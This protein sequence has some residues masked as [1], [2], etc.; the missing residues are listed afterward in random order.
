MARGENVTAVAED[1]C[2]MHGVPVGE[3]SDEVVAAA[4][5]TFH[6]RRSRPVVLTVPIDAPDG[7]KLTLEVRDG[8]QHEVS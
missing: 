3:A 2:V 1:F 6:N 4:N 7:R 8:E 5:K